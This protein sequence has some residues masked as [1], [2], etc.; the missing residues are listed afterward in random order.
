MTVVTDIGATAEQVGVIAPP[1]RVSRIDLLPYLLL[2]PSIVSIMLVIGYPFAMGFW[3]SLRSGS[4]LRPG[5]FVG[6]HNYLT[7][8]AVVEF[9][10]AAWFSL[11]FAMASVAGG[12]LLGLGLALLLNLDVPCRGFFRTAL[13]LPW[14][15]PSVVSI[16]S[17]R[18]LIVDQHAPVN[19]FLELFGFQPIYFLSTGP[20]SIAAVILIKIWRSFPFMMLSLLAA[21]QGIDRSLYE[22]AALDGASPWQAFRFITMPRLRGISVIL[23][24]LMTIWSVN[25]FETP[26]L[27]TEGG[28]SNATQNLVLLAYKYTFVRNQLGI[29]SAVS[30]ITLLVLA[31]L[32]V[33]MMRRQEAEE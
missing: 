21:L 28:P 27:L 23:W 25:D 8:P 26:W 31:I 7:L 3:Y 24:I 9:Q 11:I 32:A 33:W 1:W 18:W 15:I 20:G 10:Q 14:I 16:V 30:F 22:A 12:Y 5:A 17:W 13:L 6:L 19:Q 29:G 2:V 4:L